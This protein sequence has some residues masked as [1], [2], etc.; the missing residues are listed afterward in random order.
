MRS[1]ANENYS[2]FL[3]RRYSKLRASLTGE[4]SSLIISDE[5]TSKIH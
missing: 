1:Q 5:M 4:N 2:N 3:G